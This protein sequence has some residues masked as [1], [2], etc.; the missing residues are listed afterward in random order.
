MWYAYDGR[1]ILLSHTTRRQK[2]RNM[3]E[4]PDVSLAIADPENPF[5]YIEIRGRVSRAEPD[6]GAEFHRELRRKYGMR[7]DAVPDA[8]ERVVV[9]VTPTFI[10]GREMN[11]PSR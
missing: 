3:A 7:S 4:N 6:V 10:G 5:R 11:D 9:F 1:D 2:W 8:D